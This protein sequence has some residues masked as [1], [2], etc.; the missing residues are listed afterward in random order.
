[1]ETLDLVGVSAIVGL[2]L[3]Y[4]T[5]LLKNVGRTWPTM[6]IKVMSFVLAGVFA[7][8]TV[9]AQEGWNSFDA[10]MILGSFTVIYALAQTTY[11]GLIGG[12][13]IE[14]A[15]ASTLNKDQPVS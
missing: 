6:W 14:Q 7:F 3:P 2:L 4:L 5:S 1:V 15:L 11:K 12:T 10:N 13:K 8:V 9:G